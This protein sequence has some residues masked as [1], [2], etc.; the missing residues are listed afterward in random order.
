MFGPARR[1]LLLPLILSSPAAGAPG[2]PDAPVNLAASG[3]VTA[4]SVLE[5][6]SADKATDGNVADDARWVSTRTKGPHWLQI[7]L[8]ASLTIGSAH[9][10]TGWGDQDPVRNFRLESWDGSAWKPVPGGGAKWNTETARVL[11]FDKPIET[12]RVR[13][14]VEDPGP[15]R[16]KELLLFPPVKG[17]AKGSPEIGVGVQGMAPG[18]DPTRHHVLV[19]QVGYNT[20]W[21]KR[22]TAPLSP[23]D[24]PFEVIE[25][26]TNR[27]VFQGK[28]ARHIGDF[29]AFKPETSD[30]EYVI[31]VSGGSLA[32]AESFP[33][34]VAPMLA[35]RNSLAPALH[36]MVDSRSIVGTH[37]SAYGGTAWRD[38]TYYTFELPSI[39][40]L[41]LANPAYFEAAPVEIDYAA[42]KE[43]VLDPNFKFVPSRHDA[44]SMAAIRRYYA[45][46]DAPVGDRVPD[47]VQMMHFGVGMILMDPES[48]DPSGDPIPNKLH[49]QTV[50]QLAFFLYAYPH[51]QRYVTPK[52]YERARDF[53]FGQWESVGLFD[54][55][56]AF[57]DAKG[58][59]APG[60]SVMPNLLMHEVA[61]REGRADARRFLNAAAA[62]AKWVI[63]TFE[64]GDPRV[65]KGQRMSEHKI[66]TGLALLA[67][68]YPAAAPVGLAKWLDGWTKAVIA[69][70]DNMF[71]FRRYD[72]E[73]WS[74]PKPYNE[75]GNIAGF[76]AVALSAAP[77][78]TDGA[79]RRRLREIAAAQ[80]DNLFGR[81]P[82]NAASAADA[83]A[84]PGI[85]RPWPKRFPHD[86]CARLELCRGVL[87]SNAATEHFPFQPHKGG[88]RHCEGWTA[89]N[90]AW[91]VG[92]AYACRDATTIELTGDRVRLHAPAGADP[93]KRERVRVTLKTKDG[94]TSELEL[95]EVS[96]SDTRFEAML[97][98]DVKNVSRIS[99]GHGFLRRE[100]KFSR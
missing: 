23:D 63:E 64:P 47:A 40:L 74:V 54:V 35:H 93:A 14:F 38:G 5:Q 16:V 57:A 36:F 41:Y 37:P 2:S 65:G 15:A 80:V 25:K 45:E 4:S 33:F 79:A 85:D 56:T 17:A 99:Y 100:V 62:Q 24:S 18:P 34:H 67:R 11:E 90:A 42:D 86:V 71:D 59:I 29:T 46:L 87:N 9:L 82:M 88:F 27:P 10:H 76:P 30:A 26:G 98:A 96:A 1:L 44:D 19:N 3:T 70:S 52:F 66:V 8:P 49:D 53:T 48:H 72:D 68:D 13:L 81:N 43:K 6:Y 28:I 91:N 50:E 21:P 92:L 97:P 60:H 84:Y 20:E 51:V 78:A 12:T 75:P 61:K 83:R 69:R 55:I 95:E 39:V 94:K 58:R 73:H 77:F 89:F 7:D 32:P 22:F 31:R